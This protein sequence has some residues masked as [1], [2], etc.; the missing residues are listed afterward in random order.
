MTLTFR[1]SLIVLLLLVLAP[2]T[3]SAKG[4]GNSSSHLHPNTTEEFETCEFSNLAHAITW[5]PVEV[6]CP[7]CKTKNNFLEPMSWG[8]YI[9]H[10]PSKYQLV[11]WPHTDGASWYSCKKCRYTA[12]MGIFKDVPPEKIAELRTLLEGVYL[13]PQ[14]TITGD[15]GPHRPPYNGIPLAARIA[16][17]EKVYRVLGKTDDAFWNHFYRVKAYHLETDK[18]LAEADEA[19]KKSL[20]LS[21]R[22]L[23]DKEKA[24]SRKE[25]L[26][27]IG[28]M[29][30]FLRDGLGAL[31]SFEA[32]SKLT[33]ADKEL[34]EEQN[35]NYDEYLSGLIKEYIE[36]LEKGEGPKMDGL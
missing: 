13:P 36:M 28:A 2:V 19:R 5:A 3:T 22:M 27:L 10:Y 6:E 1:F 29:K 17:A 15:E 9:Y 21:E 30:Y 4:I 14:K 26:Y 20:A 12:F 33:L 32:A 25:V 7:V 18:K 31:K 16:V 8:S 23:A 11:F 24:G 35:K 34:D